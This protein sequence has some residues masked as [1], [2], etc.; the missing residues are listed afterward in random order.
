MA[1]TATKRGKDET[2]SAEKTGRPA[3]GARGGITAPVTPSPDLAEIVGENDLPRSEVVRRV[4]E[5]IKKHDLQDAK[6]RRQINADDR[7]EAVF[8]KRSAS[9]F[10]MNKHLS[11]HLTARK[12]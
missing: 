5:Y 3:G 6:D 1:R 8:G 10:E 9:M 7:L 11:R 12:D 4:W 2:R